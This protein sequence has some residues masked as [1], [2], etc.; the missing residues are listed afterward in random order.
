MSLTRRIRVATSCGLVLCLCVSAAGGTI[1]GIQGEVGAVQSAVGASFVI[2]T[3]DITQSVVADPIGVRSMG[4]VAG[5]TSS[6]LGG[7]RDMYLEI[8]GGVA[9]GRLRANPF[10]LNSNLQIDLSAG[11]SATATVIWDGVPGIT[12]LEPDHGLDMDFTG[13]GTYEGIAVRLAID[14]AG[15]GQMLKLLIHSS[16]GRKSEAELAFPVV[17]DVEPTVV[18]FV[19]Y[20]EFVGDADMTN[21]SAFQMII[22]AESP[23]IDAQIDVVGLSGPN[24]SD[25][26]IL[27][28]PS[29]MVL[30]LVAG[31]SLLGLRRRSA[32]VS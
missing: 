1:P 17:P 27:P 23:S 21:V 31:L 12:G 24:T 20:T 15:E 16:G 11:V 2:D 30:T 3:F 32:A 26:E 4:T 13:G 28:E 29:S 5:P 10:L 25:F 7:Y 6:I 22:N 19:P 18:Q 8:I 14:A 9:E